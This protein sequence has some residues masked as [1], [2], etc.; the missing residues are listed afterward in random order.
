M[1]L[2]DN[3]SLYYAYFHFWKVVPVLII[4]ET[5]NTHLNGIEQEMGKFRQQFLL[6]AALDLKAS[7]AKENIDLILLKKDENLIPTLKEICNAYEIEHTVTSYPRGTYEGNILGALCELTAVFTCE[8]DNLVAMDELPFTE[9]PKVFTPFRKEIEAN[10]DVRDMTQKPLLKKFKDCHKFTDSFELIQ[11]PKHPNSAFPFTGGEAAAHKRL[12]YYLWESKSILDYKQT[13]NE[14][15][16]ENYSSKLS[17]YLALGN[18]SPVQVYYAI[19]DFEA[20]VEKNDST[21]W[22]LFE[23]LWREYFILIA[24]QA[25]TKIYSPQGI[26]NKKA[27]SYTNNIQKFEQWCTGNT[28]HPFINANMKEFVATGYMSNRGRQNVASY[29]VHHLKID[30]R[31]GATFFEKHLIDYDI[32]LNWCN[33]MYVAGVGNNTRNKVFNPT[34]QQE[35]YDPENAYCSL[36]NGSIGLD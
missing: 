17:A 13:R 35:R 34:L 10:L 4:P 18:L 6:E 29:L 28:E 5:A 26:Q 31:W 21:Y 3:P 8:D 32:S 23:L 12:N 36:W 30:W 33:W 9:L 20:Q 11:H 19:K 15:I 24:L 1:R 16:G 22:L 14:L 27:K 2:Q 7:L 25:Q